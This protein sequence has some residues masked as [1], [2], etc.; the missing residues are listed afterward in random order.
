MIDIKTL[1]SQEL[2]SLRESINKEIDS[3]KQK[4]TKEAKRKIAELAREYGLSVEEILAGKEPRATSK[5]EPKYRDPATG[6]TWTGRGIHP[7]WLKAQL[8]AGK[9]VEEFLIK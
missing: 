9:S 3:R 7:A 8:E 1:S 6:K 5:V 4:D 2:V